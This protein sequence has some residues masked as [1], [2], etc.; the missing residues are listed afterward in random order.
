MDTARPARGG[1]KRH[2]HPALAGRVMA[3]GIST[4]AL[5]GIVGGLARAAAEPGSDTALP[6]APLPVALPPGTPATAPLEAAPPETVVVVRGIHRTVYVDEHGNVVGAP[7]AA[8]RSAAPRPCRR[9]GGCGGDRST[10]GRRSPRAATPST[11]REAR[12]AI[13]Q[14]IEVPV[15]QA[16]R[17]S[18]RTARTRAMGSSA[19]IIIGDG[20]P[21][22]GSWALGELARLERCWSRFDPA[23]ELC[24]LNASPATVVE[25]SPTL[26]VALRAADRLW[27][28]TGG[29]F[30][31]TVL[32][33]VVAAGYDVTFTAMSVRQPEPAPT[34]RPAPGFGAV[35]VDPS[36]AVVVRRPGVRIDLG[37]LGKGLAA[38]LV[39]VGLVDRGALGACVS[40]GGDVRAAGTSLDGEPWSIPVE[41]PFDE[42]VVARHVPLEDAAVVT[43][44]RLL[45]AWERVAILSTT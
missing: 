38:D 39:A 20:P 34:L 13:V 8:P 30:D 44:T 43:S 37:G 4:A 45:R 28:E 12:T 18:G 10:G 14:R 19:R 26:M 32:D 5:F 21:G 15:S 17:R 27:R 35:A 3:T 31:P 7:S 25:V 16:G 9:A 22:L 11:R 33:A 2:P 24:A 41:D 29:R 36:A 40:L 23:S 1:R 42:S 6:A